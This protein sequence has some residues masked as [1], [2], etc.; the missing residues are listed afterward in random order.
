MAD[1]VVEAPAASLVG[2]AR[3]PA[4]AVTPADVIRWQ[5]ATIS[6]SDRKIRELGDACS[7]ISA[8][9]MCLLKLHVDAGHAT[10]PGEVTIPRWLHDR[11][12]GATISFTN[13]QTGITVRL[14]ERGSHRVEET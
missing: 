14:R 3:F 6:E 11:M 10:G 9:A 12:L 13:D 4:A 2:R 1:V 8:I 7:A 5:S